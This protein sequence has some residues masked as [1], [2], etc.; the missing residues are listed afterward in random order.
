MPKRHIRS[1]S[2]ILHTRHA[3]RICI[4]VDSYLREIFG[5][6]LDTKLGNPFPATINEVEDYLQKVVDTTCVQRAPE[7]GADESQ[8]NSA[9]TG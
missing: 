9:F 2:D 1:D 7:L 5:L 8:I 4:S 6:P 3:K